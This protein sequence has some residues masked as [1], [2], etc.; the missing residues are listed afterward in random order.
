M[1]MGC[2]GIQLRNN[3]VNEYL[4][5]CLSTS[6]KGWHSYW[7]YVKND[8]AAPLPEFS[9]RLIEEVLE[10]WRKWVCRRKIRR[11]SRTTSPPSVS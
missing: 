9:G 11:G 2:A 5:M 1:S 7:F 3:H 10:S 8:A 6:N 4:S